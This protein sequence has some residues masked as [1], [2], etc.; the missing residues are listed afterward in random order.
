MNY[1]EFFLANNF[2]VDRINNKS[3]FNP[4]DN[5]FGVSRQYPDVVLKKDNKE[6]ILSLQGTLGVYYINENDIKDDIIP[7][8]NSMS[9]K[10]IVFKKNGTVVYK[11]L[12]GI[13]PDEKF[14]KKFVQE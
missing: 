3:K 2:S 7:L 14:I 6:I 12:T 8:M 4:Y 9:L 5:W 1:S 11:N 13:F 10:I